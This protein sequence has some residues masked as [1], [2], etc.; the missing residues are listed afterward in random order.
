M[1]GVGAGGAARCWKLLRGRGGRD[2]EPGTSRRSV[3]HSWIP[4]SNF[5]RR[6]P[7]TASPRA[8]QGQAEAVD[9]LSGLS[10]RE[11]TGERGGDTSGMRLELRPAPVPNA[12]AAMREEAEG[13]E[14]N[15][16]R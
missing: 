14:P 11:E 7:P 5:G 6:A 1:S 4:E 3:G 15:R 12:P 16:G 2:A 9:W 8:N 13:E 10:V